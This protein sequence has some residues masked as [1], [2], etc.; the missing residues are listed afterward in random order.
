MEIG[1][2]YRRI[3]AVLV[4]AAGNPD[5]LTE[6]YYPPRRNPGIMSVSEQ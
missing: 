2:S 5:G 1:M 3:V 4:A 6:R